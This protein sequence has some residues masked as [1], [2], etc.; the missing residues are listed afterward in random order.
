M[1]GSERRVHLSAL[2]SAHCATNFNSCTIDQIAVEFNH[3]SA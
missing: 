1:N 2:W 3:C